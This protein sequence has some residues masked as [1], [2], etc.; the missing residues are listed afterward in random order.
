MEKWLETLQKLVQDPAQN[1]AAVGIGVGIVVVFVVII[2][3]LLVAA[4]L[5]STSK[6]NVPAEQ[7]L[8][9]PRRVSP[10]VTM[11][12]GI[13]FILALA[14]ASVAVLYDQTSSSE[15]CSRSCHAMS[16]ASAAWELSAHKEIDCV[17]CHE[18]REWASFLTGVTNRMACVYAQKTGKPGR[19][20]Q[21]AASACI[22]CHTSMSRRTVIGRDGNEFL[23]DS[24]YSSG[25]SCTGC[26]EAQGHVPDLR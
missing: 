24:A 11:L 12:L 23:H 13:A 17:R 26:H 20:R 25:A 1:P 10:H 6:R 2:V 3:M 5:P 15:Y 19:D 8:D 7:P 16:K 21:V 4:A 18:G 22:A 14:V 9:K